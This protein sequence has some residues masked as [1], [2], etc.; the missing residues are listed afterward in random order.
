MQRKWCCQA[1][2]ECFKVERFKAE[3][4]DAQ[5]LLNKPDS[6]GKFFIPVILRHEESVS[7]VAD[8]SYLSMTALLG[9]L[10]IKTLKRIAGLQNL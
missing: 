9:L 7:S 6:S 2:K 4:L 5:T 10:Q 3:G 8:A 1:R